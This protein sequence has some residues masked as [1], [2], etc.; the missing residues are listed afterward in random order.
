MK[1]ENAPRQEPCANPRRIR[2]HPIL[3]APD[4]ETV[5]IRW[6]GQSL[7]AQDGEMIATALFAN[8]IHVFGHHARDG[9]PQGIFCA[10]GQCAQ[11]MVVADGLAVKACMEPVRAGMEVRSLDDVPELPA[12]GAPVEF[13]DVA[14]RAVDCP[15]PDEDI[16]GLTMQ[17]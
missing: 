2:E 14:E 7:E 11:C 10:N 1:K 5:T 12:D 3:T 17:G 16:T 15:L 6:N 8:G 13:H 9:S 4:R